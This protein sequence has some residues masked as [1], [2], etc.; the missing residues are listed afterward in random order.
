MQ[1]CRFDP[2]LENEDPTCFMANKF[3]KDFKKWLTK[4]QTNKQKKAKKIMLYLLTL[5]TTYSHTASKAP[6]P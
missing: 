5:K 3:N 2:W 4:K 1:G 6:P